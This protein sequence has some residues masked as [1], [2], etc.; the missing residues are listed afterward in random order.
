M[1]FKTRIS[2]FNVRSTQLLSPFG[3]GALM[4][5]NNQSILICDSED[6]K[7]DYNYIVDSRLEAALYAKGFVEAP[8]PKKNNLYKPDE[9][10]QGKRFPSWYLNPK[11]RELKTIDEW[12]TKAPNKEKHFFYQ[13]PFSYNAKGFADDLVPVRLLC[14]CTDGHL[15]EFPWMNWCHDGKP[16]NTEK[17]QLSLKSL[18]NSSSI[19]DL[20]IECSCK[21]SKSLAGVFNKENINKRLSNIDVFCEGRHHWKSDDTP[22]KCDCDLNVMLRN[23]SNLHFPVIKSS[24]NI[25]LEEN[26]LI[27]QIKGQRIYQEDILSVYEKHNDF[28]EYLNSRHGDYQ[29]DMLTDTIQSSKPAIIKALQQM[30]N[31]HQ[32]EPVSDMDYK[33]VE[34]SV[35]TG[36]MQPNKNDYTHFIIDIQKK[37]QFPTHS[38]NKMISEITLVKKLEIINALVGYSRI[39]TYESENM[40]EKDDDLKIVSLKRKDGKYVANKSKGEGI[41]FSLNPQII[42]EWYEY[43]SQNDKSLLTDIID[44]VKYLKFKDHTDYINP[45]FYL[46]HTISHLLINELTNS[47][48]YSSSSLK[49]RIYFNEEINMYGVLIYTAS[50]DENGT[51]GGL[52]K[53]GTPTK[54]FRSLEKAI[55]DSRWCGYDPVCIENKHQGRD[56]LNSAACHACSL[57]SETSCE[58]Q[59]SYLD[60]KVLIGSLDN[61]SLGFFTGFNNYI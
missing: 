20:I 36:K 46:I 43:V 10:V 15:Q 50:N 30:L 13:K 7:V 55:E 1:M 37:D 34:F 14:A 40:I 60:R 6:W 47:S 5:I 11:S 22:R 17:H 4:D 41:F 28:E 51:L 48:G 53:Q 49:E 32:Q 38:Y 54:F 56:S 52:V 35:L 57:I 23:Q 61:P 44:K 45:K 16:N 33:S 3:T 18:G 27:D 59:N 26:N 42:D 25:P 24:V 31:S 8:I 58:F 39:N 19:S 2:A 21:K 9:V 29:I 12:E